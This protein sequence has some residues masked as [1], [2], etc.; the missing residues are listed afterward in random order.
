LQ[1][2]AFGPPFLLGAGIWLAGLGPILP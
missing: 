1:R 2:A